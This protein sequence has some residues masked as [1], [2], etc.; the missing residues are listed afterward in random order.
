MRVLLSVVVLNAIL[1]GSAVAQTPPEKEEVSFK[2]VVVCKAVEEIK[3]IGEAV[4]E[5]PYGKQICDAMIEMNYR[6]VW[7]NNRVSYAGY[8]TMINYNDPGDAKRF[9][10]VKLTYSGRGSNNDHTYINFGVKL[11]LIP[12]GA[13]SDDRFML[14]CKMVKESQ[15]LFSGDRDLG[16]GRN[17]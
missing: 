13:T 6:T 3:C 8:P 12:I 11:V 1:V 5:A 16:T 10:G 15:A 14:G 9:R 7:I 2:K 4:V 17:P